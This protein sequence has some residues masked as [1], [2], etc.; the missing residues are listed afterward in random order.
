MTD[1]SAL[2]AV[3]PLDGRYARYTEPLVPYASEWALMRAR[4]RVEVEYLI[5]LS[6]IDETPF[7]TTDEERDQLRTLY[8]AF[9]ESDAELVKQIETEGYGDY[10]ATNHDVKAIEYFVREGLPE[11]L[12]AAEWIHFG[13]TSEDV[14]NLAHRLLVKSAVEEVLVLDE[15]LRDER[16]GR[17]DWEIDVDRVL[18]TVEQKGGEITVFSAEFDPGQQL[19]NLGGIAAL[20]RYRLE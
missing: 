14:N 7:E 8:E 9:D 5:A 15:R 10:S 2:Q 1:R 18:E 16:Q 4:T 3:S 11:S 13:L 19:R 20:L 12:D 17:G 6:D